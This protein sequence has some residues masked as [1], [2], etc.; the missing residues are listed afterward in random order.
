MVW[1]PLSLPLLLLLGWEFGFGFGRWGWR[2]WGMREVIFCFWL[3]EVRL[4]LVW[5][6]GAWCGV[7]GRVMLGLAGGGVWFR[8]VVFTCESSG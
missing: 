1:V 2:R 5:D 3:F 7:E 8:E 6:G 4:F